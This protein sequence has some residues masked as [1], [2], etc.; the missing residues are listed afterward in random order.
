MTRPPSMRNN[1]DIRGGMFHLAAE[2]AGL[3]AL[4]AV[5]ALLAW[6]MLLF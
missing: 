5:T 4:L 3:A 6:L 2:V 1:R